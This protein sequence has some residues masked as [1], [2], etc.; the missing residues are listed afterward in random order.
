MGDGRA[1]NREEAQ[2]LARIRLDIPNTSD[3]DWKIDIRKATARI[4]VNLRPWLTKL[5]E[6][7]RNR[8]RKVFA[9][10]GAPTPGVG[11]ADASVFIL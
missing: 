6:D 1:W 5:A 9:F 10:R 4:P 3:M 11:R 8:A 7:T 2:K